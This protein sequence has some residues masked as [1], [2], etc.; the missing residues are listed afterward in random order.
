MSDQQPGT[1]HSGLLPGAARSGAARSGA[2]LLP[3]TARALDVLVADAQ[4]RWRSVGLSAGVFRDGELVW[5]GH[6]GSARLDPPTAPTDDTPYLMGSITK[7]FTALT[8]LALRDE[9]RLE[10]DDPLSHHLP[11]TAHGS[12]TLRRLLSH[13]SGLQREPVGRV[14]ESLHMPTAE[15][16]LTG[17]GEADQV[18][19]PG[20]AFHYSNLAYGLLGHVV[21]RIEGA[22]WAEV[23]RRRVLEPLGMHRSGLAEAPADRAVGYHVHPMTRVAQI[24]PLLELRST[25]PVG[26]MW[27]T[28]ADLARYGAFLADPRPD[29]LAP[30][31]LDEMC[32]P[33]V[34]VDCDAWTRGFGL[35][36]ELARVGER[37]LVGHL[38]AMPGYHTGLRVSRADRVGAVVATNTSAGPEC[39]VLAAALVTAVLDAEPTPA[40]CWVPSREQASYQEILGTW[41]SEGER[42]ELE[43]DADQLWLRVMGAPPA[44]SSRLEPAGTDRL[45]CVEGRERGEYFEVARDDAGSVRRCYFATYPFTR[46]PTGFGTL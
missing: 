13:S 35:G 10:L 43:I 3:G 36:F 21:E 38:G 27:S 41:W 45:R 2:A 46:Q 5:S 8:V 30:A 25:V 32:R 24:E 33:V 44:M 14:W 39:G 28:V 34:M 6:V 22:P 12:L 18:L 29:I 17:L 9:G 4:R 11:G 20:E 31:T 15:E 7:T 37:V 42:Y 16:L 23:V 40:A 19:A 26:G 1:A